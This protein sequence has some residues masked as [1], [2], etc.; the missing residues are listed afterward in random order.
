MTTSASRSSS[1]RMIASD[2][3]IRARAPK[4]SSSFTE[5]AL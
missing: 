4:Y 3:R 5:R 2:I 1:S